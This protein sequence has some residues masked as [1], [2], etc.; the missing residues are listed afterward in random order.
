MLARLMTEA[1]KSHHYGL[2]AD[3]AIAA[4]TSRPALAAG[5]A[6]RVGSVVI[7][8]DADLVVWDRNPLRLGALPAQIFV[9][10]EVMLDDKS[11]IKPKADLPPNTNG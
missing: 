6:D 10:G 7:G 11:N 8:L 4:V 2:P 1:A 3:R 5:L 9:D